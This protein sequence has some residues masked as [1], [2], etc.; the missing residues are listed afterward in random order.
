MDLKPEGAF[1]LFAGNIV[2][3]TVSADKPTKLV[4][5]WQTKSPS[6]PSGAPF[7]GGADDR[8]FRNHDDQSQAGI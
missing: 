3:K 4:Q 2:G 1:E 7:R 5:S 6:W 8:S